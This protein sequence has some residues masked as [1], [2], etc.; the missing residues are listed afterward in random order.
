MLPQIGRWSLLLI[1]LASIQ[2]LGVTSLAD[3]RSR[4][5][6][7]KIDG[8]IVA[9]SRNIDSFEDLQRRT[10]HL[11]R[12]NAKY[13]EQKNIWLSSTLTL[14]AIAAVCEYQRDLLTL[15]ADLRETNRKHFHDR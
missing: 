8:I 1:L 2:L 7:D 10:A 5:W 13:S 3:T 11:S 14:A 4:S 12:S 6:D 15:F 9:L